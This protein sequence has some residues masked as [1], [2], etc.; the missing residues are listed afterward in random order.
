MTFE[1][2]ELD[3]RLLKALQQLQFSQPTTIQQLAIPEAMDGRDVMAN[4]PTGT[5]KTAAFLLP[6]LQHLLDYP[7]QK[8]GPARVLILSPTRELAEQIAF[9]ARALARFCDLVI[10]TITGGVA[11]QTHADVLGKTCDIVVATPGRL[12]EY[13]EAERFDCRAIEY[14]VIDEADRMLDMGFIKSIDRIA[15]E[16]RWRKQTLLFSATLEGRGLEHFAEDL[17]NEPARV[18]A[19][20]PRRERAKIH[21]WVHLADTLEHKQQLLEHYLRAIATPRKTDKPDGTITPDQTATLDQ[22]ATAD[23]TVNSIETKPGEAEV[24]KAIVFVKTR[25]R[26]QQLSARLQSQQIDHCYLQGDMAQDKRQRALLRFYHGKVKVLLATD[27]AARGIDVTDISHVFNFDLPRTA[28]VYVHRIGRTARAGSKGTAISLVEAHDMA[29]L[30]KI[31]RYT[32]QRLKRRV[33]DGLKPKHK[34][35]KA[36]GKA[37]KKKKGSAKSGKKPLKKRT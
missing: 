24:T 10:S 7:R 2:L 29:I 20:P 3:E 4:A 14:L 35:A 37:K 5:G 12:L 9:Q 36:P 26:L 21:Q 33:V 15:A 31:E 25:E 32:E 11:Y 1:Q 34:E 18:D 6:A 28:E 19:A 23:E 30:G 16:A 13:I 27:V 17:L 22:T 8:P